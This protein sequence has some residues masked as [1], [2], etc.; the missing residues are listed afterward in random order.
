MNHKNKNWKNKMREKKNIIKNNQ[1]RWK[2]KKNITEWGIGPPETPERKAKKPCPVLC[3]TSHPKNRFAS[4][5]TITSAVVVDDAVVVD[6]FDVVFV[7]CC[8]LLLLLLLVEIGSWKFDEGRYKMIKWM[9]RSA[10][11][12]DAIVLNFVIHFSKN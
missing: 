7:D 12:S 4:V 9:T 6:R 8:W 1:E 2:W 10:I 5:V 11:L 3:S